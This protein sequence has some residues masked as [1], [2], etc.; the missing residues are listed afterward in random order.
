M[1]NLRV[2]A[3]VAPE[4]PPKTMSE[5]TWRGRKLADLSYEELLAAAQSLAQVCIHMRDERMRADK[6]AVIDERIRRV[7]EASKGR[8][9]NNGGRPQ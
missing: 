4:I 2:G 5:Y 1:T 8:A 6:E 3:C 9:N 7:M